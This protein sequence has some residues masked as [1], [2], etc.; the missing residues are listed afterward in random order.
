MK[1]FA[2]KTRTKTELKARDFFSS[3]NIE[4]YA[5][6]YKSK[7]VWSD[8]IKKVNVSALPGYVFFR[9]NKL[10]YNLINLNPYTKNIVRN[11]LGEPAII[12]NNEISVLKNHFSGDLNVHKLCFKIGE[13][14][15]V[16]SGPMIYKNGVIEKVTNK[17]V[18]I[19]LKSLNVKFVLSKNNLV[20][21]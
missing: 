14:V 18:T 3:F 2:I 21:A 15:K 10:N 19:I 5:P 16:N 13:K 9:T 11:A 7:R 4:S 6:Y 12:S 17:N 1:W 20:A 8:R